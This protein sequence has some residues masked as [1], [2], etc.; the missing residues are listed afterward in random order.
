VNV[1][2]TSSYLREFRWYRR[3]RLWVLPTLGVATAL[4]LAA[5]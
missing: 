2:A 5:R 1:R 4:L 3:S